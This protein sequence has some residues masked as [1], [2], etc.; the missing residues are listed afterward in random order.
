MCLSLSADGQFFAI[1]ASG[2]PATSLSCLPEM[3]MQL[4]TF[5]SRQLFVFQATQTTADWA[6]VCGEACTIY[7]YRERKDHW[8]Q[9]WYKP[10]FDLF[11]QVL[12][13]STYQ[14]LVVTGTI[15]AMRALWC[16]HHI[17]TS[18]WYASL[19]EH[20]YSSCQPCTGMLLSARIPTWTHARS[21][22]LLGYFLAWVR[23]QVLAC[24]QDHILFSPVVP[25]VS[26]TCC[27]IATKNTIKGKPAFSL[28]LSLSLNAIK[29]INK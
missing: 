11:T 20:R 14:D 10:T 23:W 27:Y 4:F 6:Y 19:R 9:R 21:S 22:Y 13:T 29:I 25:T 15:Y 8:T 26:S 7:I 5:T 28:T 24:T 12:T 2:R 18:L 16:T 1:H 17:S 3:T